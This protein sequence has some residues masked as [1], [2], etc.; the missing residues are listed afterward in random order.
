MHRQWELGVN[1]ILKMHNIIFFFFKNSKAKASQILQLSIWKFYTTKY[2]MLLAAS[3][4]L[5]CLRAK[6]V[7]LTKYSEKITIYFSPR[8]R[9]IEPSFPSIVVRN[10][11][12]TQAVQIID[13]VYVG[14][15]L[16][17]RANIACTMNI[18]HFYKK[19][20]KTQLLFTD[21][22]KHTIERY[23]KNTNQLHKRKKNF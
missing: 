2:R 7:R 9:W 23:E 10:H 15:L 21:I 13:N 18:A 3:K 4:I 14:I 16:N 12:Y 22:F 1:K 8:L 17:T 11:E 20:H 5:F 19:K 6:M